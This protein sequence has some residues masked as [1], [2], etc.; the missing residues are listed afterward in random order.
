LNRRL[1]EAREEETIVWRPS[2]RL[3]EAK[4]TVEKLVKLLEDQLTKILEGLT[5]KSLASHKPNF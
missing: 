4:D 5:V 2:P 1:E 3:K